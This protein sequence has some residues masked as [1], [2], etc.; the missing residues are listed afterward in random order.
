MSALECLIV[1][2]CSHG[3]CCARDQGTALGSVMDPVDLS[4]KH[5]FLVTFNV[6]S[7]KAGA[8]SGPELPRGGERTQFTQIHGDFV[9]TVLCTEAP[10]QRGFT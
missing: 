8:I 10:G 5:S 4:G 6:S 3:H 7:R 9:V 1:I 2:C